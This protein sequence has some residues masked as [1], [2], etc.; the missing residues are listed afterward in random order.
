M[1]AVLPCIGRAA[2][3][4]VPGDR[5][6]ALKGEY[7]YV[8]F[9]LL[10]GFELPE[11]P[12][13]RLTRSPHASPGGGGSLAIP[14][15]V[16]KLHGRPASI[17]GYMLPLDLDGSRVTTFILTASI[18]AC[19]FGMV[20]QPNEWVLVRMQPGRHV[21]FAK[22]QPITVFGRLS[23]GPEWQAGELVSLYRMT[24]D[25]IAIH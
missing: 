9:W 5:V 20:G 17:R 16:Q 19:H 13:A 18:D 21:P 2:Q 25:L 24:G 7:P 22:L 23:V 3:S 15:E 8:R 1:L 11:V 4:V 12:I 10:A 6:N 14:D